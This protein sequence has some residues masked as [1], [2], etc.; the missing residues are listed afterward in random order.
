MIDTQE[1]LMECMKIEKALYRSIGYKG[2]VHAFFTQCEVGKI[3]RYIQYL[4]F[5]EY[6][7]NK[8]EKNTLDKIC[9]AYFRMRHNKLGVQL[10]MSI[11]INTFG[12]GLLVYHSQGIIVHRDSRCGNNCKLHGLNCIGNSG[13]EKNCGYPQVGN[14]LDLGVGAKIIGNIRL[15]N[16]IK[17]GSNAVACKT[18]VM[19]NAVLIGIPAKPLST[20]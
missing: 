9:G 5:D 13:T 11:P 18:C 8:R 6:Y 17:I 16:N 7:T 4:R 1:K 10:G 12:K 19:D 20:L 15:G 2:S 3:Y 14:N